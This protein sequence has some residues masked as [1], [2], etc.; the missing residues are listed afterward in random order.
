MN[1]LV[2][3]LIDHLVYDLIDH[4]QIH[5]LVLWKEREYFLVVDLSHT[6][7]K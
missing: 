6:E 5:I 3:D 7:I 2:Y 4:L 1:N